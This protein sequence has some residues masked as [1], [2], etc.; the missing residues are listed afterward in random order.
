MIKKFI[1]FILQRSKTLLWVV[2]V[3]SIVSGLSSA[4]VIYFISR[5][6]SSSQSIENINLLY[7]GILIVGMFSLDYVSK[8]LLYRFTAIIDYDLKLSFSQQILA[9]PLR[10]LEEI[11][12][13]RLMA[14]L[15]DDVWK[16]ITALYSLPGLITS[17]AVTLGCVVYMVWL[18]PLAVIVL[19]AT[20]LP[21]VIVHQLI[22]RRAKA[23]TRELIQNRNVI[24][25]NYEGLIEGIKELKVN[26][27]RGL[28][29][30]NNTLARLMKSEFGLAFS[31]N[32][33]FALSNAIN[34][35]IYFLLI[36]VL[37]AF[38]SML[39]VNQSVLLSYTLIALYLR[40]SVTQILNAMPRW[41][42]AVVTMK[43][44]EP[45]G[46]EILSAPQRNQAVAEDQVID[47]W[48]SLN[49]N[50]LKHTYYSQETN[51]HFSL[52]PI[53]LSFTPGELIFLIGGNGSGK[54]T[55][56]K[57]LT[58]LYR[59]ENGSISVD[60]QMVDENRLIRYRSLFS[61]IFTD[62]YLFNE[63]LGMEDPALDERAQY[64]IEK[65]QLSHKVTIQ[66][67]R[68]STTDLSQ[69]QRQRLALLTALL[70]DRPICVFDE[71]AAGQD[72]EFKKLFYE[73]FLP[74]LRDRGKLIIASSHDDAYFP[75]ADRLI[76]LD[77]G[78]IEFDKV[79]V[80]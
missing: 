67:G 19:S 8:R 52:G 65:L 27:S 22:Y 58:G 15:T 20:A 34:Q 49:L 11:G 33:L 63:M 64:Y 13:P 40:T 28:D 4:A 71:W 53:D 26:L 61:P 6:L 54:T 32:N 70:E 62:F 77:Y 57:L 35:G 18:S 2:V 3:V 80:S 24:F 76:K 73:E 78:Q 44:I 60:N 7:F 39:E 21:I 66:N 42:T 72:P 37:F 25:Q 74:E 68:L 17:L 47:T 46:F 16:I 59:P 31:S 5:W 12:N 50:S 41:T 30:L 36:L 38:S 14:L 1:K 79:P 69:G 56:I 45:F 75:L 51:A 55:L 9:K 10:E 48:S 43:G 29:F 23:Q